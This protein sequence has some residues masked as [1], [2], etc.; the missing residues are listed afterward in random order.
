MNEST[1]EYSLNQSK[2]DRHLRGNT[3]WNDVQMGKD[4]TPKA[5]I[6]PSTPGACSSAVA[7]SENPNSSKNVHFNLQVSSSSFIKAQF[8]TPKNAQSSGDQNYPNNSTVA[9]EFSITNPFEN[10]STIDSLLQPSLSPSIFDSVTNN[11][12]NKSVSQSP[13]S[14]WNIDQI[15]IMNPVDIDLSKLHEQQNFVKLEP[16]M[17]VKAQ[18]AIDS[19]FA[20]GVNLT[21][22]WS[23]GDRPHYLAIISPAVPASSRKKSARRR[24]PIGTPTVFT[25][26]A[27]LLEKNEGV[28]REAATVG[29]QTMLSIP[30]DIDLTK[31]LGNFFFQN[32]S[33]GASEANEV[34]SNSS[35]RRKL[36]FHDEETENLEDSCFEPDEKLDVETKKQ[37]EDLDAY[38]MSGDSDHEKIKLFSADK[39]KTP[40][41]KSKQSVAKTPSSCQSPFSSSPVTGGRMFDLGTPCD[42]R[43]TNELKL[44]CFSPGPDYSPIRCAHNERKMASTTTRNQISINSSILTTSCENYATSSVVG[45][46]PSHVLSCD[47]SS[48]DGSNKS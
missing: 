48:I 12:V 32:N 29:T 5:K 23:S 4:K 22:P 36:F 27:P 1:A 46:L 34:L 9:S 25:P 8:S 2:Y 21:S 39:M 19:F 18:K 7:S 3:T 28:K 24:D 14:F 35:L 16:A 13:E 15:A 41:L 40:L 17:E 10:Q 44:D 45:K 20:Q 33:K 26:S 37:S 30:A 31:I 6:Q 38:P 47:I 11:T 43:K 42:L